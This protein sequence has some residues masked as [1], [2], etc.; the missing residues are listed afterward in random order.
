MLESTIFLPEKRSGLVFQG[1]LALFLLALSGLGFLVDSQQKNGLYFV[2]WLVVSLMFIP[3]A[4][5]LIYRAYTLAQASY[6]LER[7]GLR[8]RWGLRAEDISLRWIEWI[9]PANELG[10]ELRLPLLRWQGALVGVQSTE[11]L[12]E[13]EF[14]ASDPE[15]LLL[16]ATAQKVYAISPLDSKGFLRQFQLINEM[17]SLTDLPVYSTRAGAFIQETWLDSRARILML[18]GVAFTFALFI[19]T[20]VFIPTQSS[21]SMGFDSKGNL[22]PSGPPETL[23]LFPVLAGLALGIDLVAGFYFYH[24]E[25]SPMLAYLIWASSSIIPILLLIVLVKLL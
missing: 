22:M 11:G 1:G 12:G 7:E 20:S 8:L 17:G 14:M 18:T 2:I 9:R 10:F 4:V 23:L 21:V 19:F 15:H 3:P 5:L 24:R 13:V 16:V 6:I 25:E